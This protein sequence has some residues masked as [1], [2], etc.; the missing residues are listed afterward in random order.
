M[1][2]EFLDDGGFFAILT[3]ILVAI[4]ATVTLFDALSNKEDDDAVDPDAD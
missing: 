3:L 2:L 1:N 4:A